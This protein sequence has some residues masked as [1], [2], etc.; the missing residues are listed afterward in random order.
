LV[1]PSPALVDGRLPGVIDGLY[2]VGSLALDDYRA[3]QSDIDFVAVT[4]DPLDDAACD[5]LQL[6]HTELRPPLNFDGVYVTCDELA[7]DPA[8]A[9]APSAHQGRVSR[10]G[11]LEA[12][13]A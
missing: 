12:N 11:R 4:R 13:P 7:A 3:G 10:A 9:R 1:G 8:A 6:V 2:L 5:Q